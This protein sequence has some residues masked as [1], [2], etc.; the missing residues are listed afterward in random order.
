MPDF[1]TTT[2]SA[3]VPLVE[4][5]AISERQVGASFPSEEPL[6]RRPLAHELPFASATDTKKDEA[7]DTETVQLTALISFDVMLYG[8]CW[9]VAIV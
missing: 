5:R 6:W 7:Q 9:V 3:A 8:G 1:L 4:A 2:G